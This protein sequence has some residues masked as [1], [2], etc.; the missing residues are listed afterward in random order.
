M[1]AISAIISYGGQNN[2]RRKCQGCV[3]VFWCVHAITPHLVCFRTL[4]SSGLSF[5]CPPVFAVCLSVWENNIA[6]WIAKPAQSVKVH[7][8]RKA[9]S[10]ALR[11]GDVHTLTLA[12]LVFQPR[13]AP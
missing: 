6:F 5:H 12:Q 2:F 3:S 11:G 9:Q 4:L 13:K 1:F 7:N 8:V 10:R